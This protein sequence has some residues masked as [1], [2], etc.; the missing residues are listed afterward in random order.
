MRGLREAIRLYE[1]EAGYRRIPD[2]GSNPRSNR[3]HQK[4]LREFP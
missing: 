3:W 2:S 4:P 1:I